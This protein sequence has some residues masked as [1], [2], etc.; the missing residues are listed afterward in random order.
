MIRQ[1]VSPFLTKYPSH[2]PRVLDAVAYPPHNLCHLIESY[3]LYYDPVYYPQFHTSVFA[4]S[5]NFCLWLRVS[6][7][8]H[9]N[10]CL[11]CRSKFPSDVSS[12]LSVS[13]L[14]DVQLLRLS[15]SHP[16]YMMTLHGFIMW[17]NAMKS[18]SMGCLHP[19][20]LL[21]LVPFRQESQ[22]CARNMNTSVQSCQILSHGALRYRSCR[23]RL[24]CNIFQP[25]RFH[26]IVLPIDA[27]FKKEAREVKTTQNRCRGLAR[28][29]PL[30]SVIVK[31]SN[32][33]SDHPLMQLEV[34]LGQIAE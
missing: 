23:T 21:R 13:V 5:E 22:L 31:N 29:A 18:T 10:A 32:F 20:Y 14:S 27:P 15:A 19:Y 2:V 12:L 3:P 24:S 33:V 28:Q 1:P 34:P 26:L 16:V 25:C 6:L 4:T 17:M 8:T 11:T 7:S 9:C 30:R